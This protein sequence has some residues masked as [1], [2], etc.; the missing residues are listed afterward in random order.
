VSFLAIVAGDQLPDFV[1]KFW[2]YGVTINGVHYGASEPSQ[3]HR[4]WPGAGF[5]HSIAFGLAI[6]G[7]VYLLTKSKP[8][9]I[10]MLLGTA[11]HVLV[12]INDSV[13]TMMLFPLSTINFSIDTW[14]YAATVEGGRY[15]DAAAYY[16]SLGLV[17]DVAWLVIVL[18]SWRVLTGAYWREVVVPADPKV[19]AWLGRRMPDRVLLAL[20]RATFFYGL[21]RLVA[22]STWAHLLEDYRFD[23]SWGGPAWIE[24]VSLDEVPIAVTLALTV[25]LAGAVYL[26][27]DRMVR[28]WWPAPAPV[29]AGE[30]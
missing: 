5:S 2:T 16:S 11:A 1:A 17:M 27:T 18:L 29:G 13:G 4:G 19:W 8:W 15:L 30:P 9:F 24:Q 26:F 7:L 14:A 28:R 6:A 23:L 20:Y 10:G 12:D 3:F 21:T 25:V 22:W